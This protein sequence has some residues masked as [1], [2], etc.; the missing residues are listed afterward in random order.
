MADAAPAALPSA[1]ATFTAPA[2]WRAVDFI[3]DLHLCQGLPA[4]LQAWE[5][6]LRHTSA[7]AVFMLGDLFDAWVGDDARSR[8]FERHCVDVLAQAAGRRQLAFMAGNRDFLVGSGLLRAAGMLGLADP[9]VL[10]AWGRRVLLSHGDALCLADL[11][12]QAFRVEVR[13]PRWQADFLAQPLAER[14]DIAAE[15]RRNSTARRRVD[16][17]ADVDVD[18]AAALRWLQAADAADL[19]HGHTHRPG[20]HTLAPGL[21]RH[22]LSDWN[23]DTAA[24]AEV[25][26]LTRQG[27]ERIPPTAA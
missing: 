24:R 14:L 3:S 11:P 4:T 21:Q 2:G 10:V 18:A 15:M 7:D 19:V 20:S 6:H 5:R 23:L 27:F 25:L 17:D 13:S 22:V 8:P 12:Y 16:G 26:R 9:T 1:L